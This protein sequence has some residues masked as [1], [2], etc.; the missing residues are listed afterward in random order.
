[1]T[2]WVINGSS[3]RRI[4]CNPKIGK[5]QQAQGRRQK[6]QLRPPPSFLPPPAQRLQMGKFPLRRKRQEWENIHTFPGLDLITEAGRPAQCSTTPSFPRQSFPLLFSLLHSSR[7]SPHGGPDQHLFP[8]G[9]HLSLKEVTDNRGPTY[10][11]LRRLRQ[12]TELLS[13][14]EDAPFFYNLRQTVCED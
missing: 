10:K 5:R 2:E 7:K 6:A 8:Q 11:V 13:D 1:M 4:P 9:T 12:R 3:S 14:P